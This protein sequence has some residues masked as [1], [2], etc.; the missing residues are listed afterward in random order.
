MS[1]MHMSPQKPSALVELVYVAAHRA[2]VMQAQS[3]PDERGDV[4]VMVG[5]RVGEHYIARQALAYR[6]QPFSYAA[7]T[8]APRR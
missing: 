6:F 5:M 4:F 2:A 3:A 8:D 1:P 7:G